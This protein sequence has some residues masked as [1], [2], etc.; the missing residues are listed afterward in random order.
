MT[1]VLGSMMGVF[2]HAGAVGAPG[3][4]GVQAKQQPYYK[5]YP[6]PAGWAF[7]YGTMEFVLP[8]GQRIAESVSGPIFDVKWAP[9]NG[10]GQVD[11]GKVASSP[12][13]NINDAMA[14]MGMIC[15]RLRIL[16]HDFPFKNIAT[17]LDAGQVFTAIVIDGKPVFLTDDQSLFPSDAFI[18]QLR[19]LIP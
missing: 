11:S 14:R 17:F 6:I 19:L 10:A 2:G 8:G 15:S 9:Q 18:S 13:V 1:S 12:P 3:V 4:P 5:G 7:D 16:P